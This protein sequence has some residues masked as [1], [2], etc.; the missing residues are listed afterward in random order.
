M[1]IRWEG[2]EQDLQATCHIPGKCPSMLFMLLFLSG[3]SNS[4]SGVYMLR[5][6]RAAL[7]NEYSPW[8]SGR[9]LDLGQITQLL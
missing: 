1:L 5:E 9:V 7:A 4:D 6:L 3:V 8:I 2:G